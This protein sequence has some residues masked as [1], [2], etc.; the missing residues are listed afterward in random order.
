MRYAELSLCTLGG[1]HPTRE[2]M[3]ARLVAMLLSLL[4]M[5]LGMLWAIF[6]EDNLSWHDRHSRTYLRLS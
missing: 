2:Q 1:E 4:P 6:D 3:K 5:G